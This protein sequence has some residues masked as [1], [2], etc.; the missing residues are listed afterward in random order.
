M[1][2]LINDEIVQPRCV[3]PERFKAVLGAVAAPVSVVTT[4]AGG[5]PHGT[6]VSAFCSLSLTPPLM[7]VSLDEASEL[8]ALV[9]STGR[10]A[11][12]VLAEGQERLAT[13]FARKGTDKF[14]DV[15]WEPDRGLPRLPGSRA[16]IACR[17]ERLVAGGDHVVVMGLVEHAER[18]GRHSLV[19]SERAFGT[20][21]PPEGDGSSP[22]AATRPSQVPTRGEK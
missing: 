5:R 7:L 1:P 8:L 21:H 16:F 17:V 10:F 6:T 22:A 20:H 9:R 4:A 11:V 13:G 3:D 19:Y 18:T 2:S 12:N 14:A 15:A